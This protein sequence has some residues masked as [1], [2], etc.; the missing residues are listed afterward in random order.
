MI[1]L[2]KK[3]FL[4]FLV[5]ILLGTINLA[6]TCGVDNL[7]RPMRLSVSGAPNADPAT[8]INWEVVKYYC[9]LYDSLLMYNLDGKLVPLLAESW[10]ISEDGLSYTFKLKKGVKFHDGSELTASDVVFSL[11]RIVNIK[12]G[13]SY[14]FVDSVKKVEAIDDYTV[15]FVLSKPFSAF[16]D[17]L[18]RFYVLNEELIMANLDMNHSIYNYGDVYGDYGR[19][20]LLTH[21]AGSGPYV[22]REIEQQNYLTA[23]QFKDYHIPLSENAPTYIHFINN[24]AAVFVR[25]MLAQRELE[26]SDCWQ[27]AENIEA[28]SKIDGVT[29]A[30]YSNG[31]VHLIMFNCSLPPT[32]DE[33]FRKALAHLV[34]YDMI[35]KNVFPGSVRSVGPINANTPGGATQLDANPYN[36]DL[37]KAKEYLS[38]SKYANQLDEYPVEY[39]CN[40]NVAYQQKIALAVQAE[41]RKMGIKIEIVSAPFLNLVERVARS[42]TAPNMNSTSQCPYYF[43]AGICLSYYTRSTVGTTSNAFWILDERFDQMVSDAIE[44]MDTEKR[45]AAYAEIE[46]IILDKCYGIYLADVTERIAYQSRY[47]YW[48]AVE[49]YFAKTGK[50]SATSVGFHYWFPDFKVYPEKMS[51]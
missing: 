33:Y 9:N 50:L 26:I 42:E 45:Y 23:D 47:V 19:D 25:T 30:N 11:N 49:E 37:E 28:M 3:M 17:S 5:L 10:I 40:S 46:E 38:L 12:E 35:V 8:G 6:A 39:F 36:Y 27:T 16:L 7:E 4:A 2:W 44:I 13:F 18:S 14:M 32:D 15:Q 29:I 34:D 21:D 41:A 31:A 43:E 24:T 20:F 51:E 22:L 48:P 1:M